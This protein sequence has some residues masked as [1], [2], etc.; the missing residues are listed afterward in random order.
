MA[1]R[2]NETTTGWI[3]FVFNI[4][5]TVTCAV[6]IP[7]YPTY[8][9]VNAIIAGLAAYAAGKLWVS[10]RPVQPGRSNRLTAMA[11]QEQRE[12]ALQLRIAAFNLHANP[13]D[14]DTRSTMQDLLETRRTP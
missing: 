3:L 1:L 2:M 6:M 5:G 4:I 12:S 7:L 11:D 8:A 10:L 14:P 9:A 13:Y